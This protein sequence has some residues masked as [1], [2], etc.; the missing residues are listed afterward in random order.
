MRKNPLSVPQLVKNLPRRRQRKL[1]MIPTLANLQMPN[2]KRNTPL[3]NRNPSRP[4]NSL[5]RRRRVPNLIPMKTG[6]KARA[7]VPRKE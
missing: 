3:K 6:E 7:R 1:L 2:L 4:G 5:P